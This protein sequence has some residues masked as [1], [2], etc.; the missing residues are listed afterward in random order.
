MVS[1][2]FEKLRRWG[3]VCGVLGE[4]RFPALLTESIKILSTVMGNVG[5]IGLGKD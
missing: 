5:E 1:V 2:V 4:L 3:V